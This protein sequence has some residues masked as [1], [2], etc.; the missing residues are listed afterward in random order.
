MSVFLMKGFELEQGEAA[1]KV[2]TDGTVL[3]AYTIEWLLKRHIQPQLILDVG[4]GTGVIALMLAQKFSSAVVHAIE[5]DHGAAETARRNF[6]HSPFSSRLQLTEGDYGLVRAEDL[7]DRYDL[8]VSNPPYHN[9]S[10]LPE[11]ERRQI[12][13]HSGTLPPEVFF[14]ISSELLSPRGYI[15]VVLPSSQL[16]L[17]DHAAS[18]FGLEMI[19]RCLI[20]TVAG[21]A[22][23]RVIGLWTRGEKS[24]CTEEQLT[25]S[26]SEGYSDRYT[27]L[28]RDFL[29]IF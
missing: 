27:E 16:P 7:T 2:G 24:D 14:G 20:Q 15:A 26:S 11:D 21:K 17:Y 28:M 6:S 4:T 9:G 29:T 8:I 25:I 12:A 3:G 18:S 22:C 10:Y 5:I 13:R 1:M 19:H 23:K